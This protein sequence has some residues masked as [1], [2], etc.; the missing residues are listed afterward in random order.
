MVWTA[1]RRRAGGSCIVILFDWKFAYLVPRC[2]I[3]Y[4]SSTCRSSNGAHP[5]DGRPGEPTGDPTPGGRVA[6]APQGGFGS[7]QSSNWKDFGSGRS[8]LSVNSTRAPSP[9]SGRRLI[10]PFAFRTTEKRKSVSVLER[11]RPKATKSRRRYSP[12]SGASPP[13][14]AGNRANENRRLRF[15]IR[16]VGGQGILHQTG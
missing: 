2:R 16:N 4:S 15:P 6:G 5:C 1:Q 9:K 13:A 11:R 8:V 7:V 14:I 10:S 3:V 12:L